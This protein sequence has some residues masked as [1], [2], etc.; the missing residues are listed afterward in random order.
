[1]VFAYFDFVNQLS[2]MFIEHMVCIEH[3]KMCT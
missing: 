1:M 3:N 2:I